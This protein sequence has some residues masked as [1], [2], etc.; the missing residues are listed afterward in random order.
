M[1][2]MVFSYAGITGWDDDGGVFRYT[3]PSQQDYS[4]Y[5]YTLELP[6]KIA[7][8]IE[9]SRTVGCEKIVYPFQSEDVC[10]I[11]KK[12]HKVYKDMGLVVGYQFPLKGEQ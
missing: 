7:L 1:K 10:G 6:A 2:K 4:G 8:A 12:I 9:L 3:T 11:V 5:T